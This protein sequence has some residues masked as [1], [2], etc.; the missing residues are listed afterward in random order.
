M[1]TGKQKNDKPG[2]QS[3]LHPPPPGNVNARQPNMVG[4]NVGLSHLEQPAQEAEELLGWE[5]VVDEISTTAIYQAA[6]KLTAK[7][8]I[9]ELITSYAKQ[10][11]ARKV[12]FTTRKMLTQRSPTRSR[13]PLV[14][15]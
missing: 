2:K 10:T 15:M 6:M 3:K 7:V 5:S 1:D 4:L 11:N 9:S 12:C 8:S 13:G 14:P